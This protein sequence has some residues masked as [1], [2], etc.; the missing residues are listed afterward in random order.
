[1]GIYVCPYSCLLSFPNTVLIPDTILESICQSRRVSIDT[2][3]GKPVE[4]RVFCIT[5]HLIL[6]FLGAYAPYNMP[7]NVSI[8]LY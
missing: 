1:M 2:F 5:K 7:L 3:F 4:I 6:V 8:N